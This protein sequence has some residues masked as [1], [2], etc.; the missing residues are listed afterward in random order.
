MKKLISLVLAI[1]MLVSLVPTLALATEAEPQASNTV[2]L[3]DFG[4]T[5]TF[6]TVSYSKNAAK[7]SALAFEGKDA[8]LRWEMDITS[9]SDGSVSNTPELDLVYTASDLSTLPDDAVINVRFY[10]ENAGSKFNLVYFG[11]EGIGWKDTDDDGASDLLV[12]YNEAV[13]INGGWQVHSMSL[14]S[15]LNRFRNYEEDNKITVRFNDDGWSNLKNGGYNDGDTVYIDEI[16]VDTNPDSYYDNLGADTKLLWEATDKAENPKGSIDADRN[17]FEEY[18][19]NNVNHE[20]AALDDSTKFATSD[21]TW[22]NMWIYSDKAQQ[23]GM[24]FTLSGEFTKSESTSGSVIRFPIQ[25]LDWTGW[26]LVSFNVAEDRVS[27]DS[28]FEGNVTKLRFDVGKWNNLTAV[29]K[30]TESLIFGLDGVWLSNTSAQAA[31]EEALSYGNSAA[32]NT[33]VIYSKDFN[34]KSS[35]IRPSTSYH[36]TNDLNASY[37]P[38]NSRMYDMSARLS[39]NSVT[40]N[41]ILNLDTR[42][43][44]AKMASLQILDRKASGAAM[45]AVTNN[46]YLNA[47]IYNPEPKYTFDG[48][49]PAEFIIS[50]GH[51]GTEGT[52][53]VSYSYVAVR[54]DWSGWKLISIPVST[55]GTNFATNG[56]AQIYISCNMDRYSRETSGAP[57]I[58]TRSDNNGYVRL[59]SGGGHNVFSRKYTLTKTDGVI[60]AASG[61]VNA[62][63]YNYID[64]ERVWITDGPVTEELNVTAA[65]NSAIR[66]SQTDSNAVTLFTTA[67]NT[68]AN[69]SVNVIK[70]VGNTTSKVNATYAN[71]VLT[72]PSF[73]YGASYSVV[74]DITGTNGVK[75]K[76]EFTFAN[77]DIHVGDMVVDGKTA[78]ITM[79]GNLGDDYANSK[80]IAAVYTSS[81]CDEL[82]AAYV[83]IIDANGNATVTI[84]A[85]TDTTDKTVRFFF[86]NNTES[87]KPLEFD[88]QK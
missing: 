32:L 24:Y 30:A 84:P 63:Y 35:L 62:N 11:S 80:I 87:I 55:W 21:Y 39:F 88:I 10:S 51:R 29:N 67:E 58:V 17:L 71:G 27:A 25:K 15:L 43:V 16:W 66:C 59:L 75:T 64:V 85:E 86:F 52:S 72:L 7:P 34:T 26:K 33:N 8:S 5:D 54:A 74:A 37:T 2:T 70:T 45:L 69:S 38:Y 19:L 12:S 76:A 3:F 73:E 4:N 18:T 83:G 22:I 42:V 50:L 9:T 56:I 28:G 6:N 77:E 60:T 20:F 49:T 14:K 36:V 13:T 47:W 40:Y 44:A 61:E 23:D 65:D 53:S 41:D 48:V 81:S 68:V 31:Y 79:H 46:S 78:T 82:E 1:A 57:K